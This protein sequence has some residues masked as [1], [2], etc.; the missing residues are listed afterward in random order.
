MRSGKQQTMSGDHLSRRTFLQKSAATAGVLAW[1]APAVV[2]GRNLNEKLN[3][4]LV[5][6]LCLGFKLRVCS[7]NLFCIQLI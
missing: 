3:I 1:S 2:R 5:K 7:Q 4:A 6:T